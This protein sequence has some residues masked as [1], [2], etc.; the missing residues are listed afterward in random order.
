MKKINFRSRS[1]TE[2][3]IQDRPYPAS[4]AVPDW[5]K[6]AT[7]YNV[8][9]RNPEG[10]KFFVSNRTSNATFKKCTPMLDGLTSGYII[11]LWADV[12]VTQTDP[13]PTLTWRTV[14]DVFSLHGES[15]RD[16]PPPPGYHN[17]VL[18]Y[19]NAWIPQT[20]PG[21]SIMVTS[22]HGYQDL[23]FKAIPAVLD[24]D[25][26]TLELL[27]PMWIKRDYEGVV[28]RGTPLVQLTP[29][30]REDWQAEF[31]YYEDSEYRFIV[32]ER[33]FNATLVN[34]YIKRHWSKKTYK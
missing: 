27:F 24:S 12:Q 7:P 3:E 11:P 17:I 13:V 8:E 14:H 32:E 25:R 20:P 1:K 15:A 31:D 19:H 10:K 33:N 23:P 21:Y 5:W 26:S 2:F 22:P 6:K 30:K 29:F 28:E 34:H 18:K 16:V 4:Q 9:P